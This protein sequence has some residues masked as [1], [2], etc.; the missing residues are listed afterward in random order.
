MSLQLSAISFSFD[1]MEYVFLVGSGTQEVRMMKDNGRIT[2]QAFYF[3]VDSE[4]A[5][6]PGIRDAEIGV[7]YFFTPR[8]VLFSP[9]M[10]T[11]AFEITSSNTCFT[12]IM[13]FQLVFLPNPG[14]FTITPLANQGSALVFLNGKFVVLATLHSN[15]K[16]LV[17]GSL[18]V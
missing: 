18:Q 10:Q 17:T 13:A 2:E 6:L 4:P 9:F 11:V 3:T 14:P 15:I 12:E 8:I 1:R 16:F 7:D 5:G